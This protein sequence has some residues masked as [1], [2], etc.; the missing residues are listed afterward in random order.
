MLH[1]HRPSEVWL[2]FACFSLD[3]SPWC[4]CQAEPVA[5][6]AASRCTGSMHKVLER[7]KRRS[8]QPAPVLS[9]QSSALHCKLEV[10]NCIKQAERPFLRHHCACCKAPSPCASFSMHKRRDSLK[11][12]FTHA[13]GWTLVQ[14]SS[15]TR[16]DLQSRDMQHTPS[17]SVQVLVKCRYINYCTCCG[18]WAGR[19]HSPC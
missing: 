7:A 12:F 19:A 9:R 16:P 2:A 3:L 14:D 5:A 11:A 1:Y 6:A 4:L 8:G 10:Q 17:F 15:A 18:R 13:L